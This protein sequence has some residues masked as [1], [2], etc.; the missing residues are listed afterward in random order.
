MA[1]SGIWSGAVDSEALMSKGG[2]LYLGMVGCAFA[3]VGVALATAGP[4][5]R[6]TSP[7]PTGG[8]NTDATTPSFLNFETGQIPPGDL[9]PDGSRLLVVNT[10]DSRLEVFDITSGVPVLLSEI[11]VGLDPISVRAFSS[12]QAWVVNNISD[13]VSVVDLTARN[14]VASLKTRDEPADVV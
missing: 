7:P 8:G 6:R 4:E 3:A 12:T 13:S 5:K 10:A 9:P 11:P 14:V 1:G 2:I